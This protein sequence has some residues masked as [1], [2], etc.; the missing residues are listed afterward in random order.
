MREGMK[1]VGILSVVLLIC[2]LVGQTIWLC[3][4]REIK[5]GEFR[6]KG[7]FILV[8]TVGRFLDEEFVSN[9]LNFSCGLDSEEKTFIWDGGK[10]SVEISS[11][12]MYREMTRLV[13]YDYL[14]RNN[15]LNL[16]KID[17]LYKCCLQEKG[18]YESP[19]LMLWDNSTQET[20]MAT[21]T[22]QS[23]RKQLFTQPVKVGYECKHQLVAAFREPLIFRSMIWH[24]A[25]E[26]VFLIGFI[27]CLIWQW[28]MMRMTWR[29]A[30]VQTMGIAHLEHELK[31][32]LAAI[33][34][35][36]GG[37]VNRENRELSE[38]QELKLQIVMASLRK[39]ADVM[40]TMLAALKISDL[41]LERTPLDI[42]KEM[43]LTL[44]MFRILRPHARVDIQIAEGI[45]RPLLDM[46][47]FN[48][49]VINLID[50]GIKYSGDAPEVKVVF[51]KIGTNWRL[52]VIDN[53]IGMS[54]RVLKRIFR[55][56]YRVKD[57][58]VADKTGFGLG[59]AFVKKVVDA[60][61]GEIR[62]ES[63]L[64]VG[65]RFIILLPENI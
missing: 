62:V 35:A 2:V 57:K 32:P 8:E 36:V 52:T 20:L 28:K 39:M 22:L 60:Y 21:D 19:V 47:Y 54:P 65:S 5:V 43:D 3:K 37:I 48:Y 6:N 30:K 44:E 13:F 24:L 16:R 10:K 33:I 38:V 17:S 27:W 7:T 53:G 34:S 55:Q 46:V 59:L 23:F 45:E 42:R 9:V 11:M 64:G 14:Y 15:C 31:K 18:I 50:N 1:I 26:G 29:S 12:K 49:L 40:D 58:R 51:E 25:W 56:F 63:R 61:G 4:I 41:E